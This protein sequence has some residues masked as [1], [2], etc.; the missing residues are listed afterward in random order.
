MEFFR[1]H[2]PDH[3]HWRDKLF[4]SIFYRFVADCLDN[5]RQTTL[6][7]T[8]F[9]ISKVVLNASKN[10]LN[11]K[12]HMWKHVHTT[13]PLSSNPSKYKNH[14]PLQVPTATI[15]DIQG[16]DLHQPSMTNVEWE[17]TILSIQTFTFGSWVSSR[18]ITR[19]NKHNE[20]SICILSTS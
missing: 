2:E 1:V 15:N 10:E 13:Q 5:N 20:L 14:Q 9:Y 12:Q 18:P 7:S 8:P 4:A 19:K 3:Q 11:L 16:R 6:L 17:N